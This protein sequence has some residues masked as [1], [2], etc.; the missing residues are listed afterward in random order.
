VHPD[1]GAAT[2]V[3]YDGHPGGAGFAERGHDAIC[4]W[5]TATRATISSCVCESGCPSCVHSP[6]CGNGNSPLDKVAAVTI[7]DAVLDAMLD[8]VPDAV[9]VGD[10]G[11]VP[12]AVPDAVAVPAPVAVAD[13]SF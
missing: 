3:V 10:G 9:A 7:L 12:D 11:A 5:L 4:E 8:A 13:P 1:T 6:K 2:I